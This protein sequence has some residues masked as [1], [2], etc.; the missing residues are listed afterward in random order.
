MDRKNHPF[1]F[2]NVPDGCFVM[3]G[4]SIFQFHARVL[5][6]ESIGCSGCGSTA[7]C[8]RYIGQ[9]IRIKIP[10]NS[11]QP[12]L[13]SFIT[14]LEM[15]ELLFDPIFIL[16]LLAAQMLT[17]IIP[18]GQAVDRFGL[19]SVTG[20]LAATAACSTYILPSRGKVAGAEV[21]SGIDKSLHEH[22][23]CT[24]QLFF[25]SPRQPAGTLWPAHARQDGVPVPG[26]KSGNGCCSPPC[27]GFAPWFGPTS[28]SIYH[29]RQAALEKERVPSSPAVLFWIR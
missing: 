6:K 22:R 8:L 11:Q 13:E 3:S 27:S 15:I 28:R 4:K 12:V 7:A 23:T 24:I 25:S 1:M 17:K 2:T 5:L 14:E 26:A 16:R 9:G 18:Q 29:G 10:V 20:V 21:V 19:G